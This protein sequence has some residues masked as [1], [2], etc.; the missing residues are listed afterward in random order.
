LTAAQKIT[1]E[2]IDRN[3]KQDVKEK[4]YMSVEK[5]SEDFE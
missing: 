1:K 5:K 4:E 3:N 2:S